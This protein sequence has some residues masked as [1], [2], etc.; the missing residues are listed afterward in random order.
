MTLTEEG[1]EHTT[2]VTSAKMKGDVNLR[3]CIRCAVR[4]D[5]GIKS[6]KIIIRHKIYLKIIFA[7]LSWYKTAKKRLPISS[8]FRVRMLKK[9]FFFC[10]YIL[11]LKLSLDRIL[12]HLKRL[13]KSYTAYKSV[14]RHPVSISS[15]FK[16]P[17]PSKKLYCIFQ[18]P[19]T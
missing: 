7:G 19:W 1:R 11:A 18:S 6:S 12:G 14:W 9:K 10:F 2:V 4:H 15:C 17:W 8:F 16:L 3:R 13:L 5:K